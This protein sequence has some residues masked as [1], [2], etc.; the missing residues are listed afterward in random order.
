[1]EGAPAKPD[2]PE[3]SQAADTGHT[4]GR[5][6]D[7]R[8]LALLALGALVGLALA[9]WS[10]LS[11]GNDDDAP[12]PEGAVAV[13]NGAPIRLEDY[14]RLLDG[15][16][17]D[18]REP[19]DEARRRHVLD[20]MI[21]EELLVQKAIAL[22]LA[23]LDRR[24]R[25]ELTSSVIQ[26]VVAA[27]EDREPEE[28]E[29]RRFYDENRAFFSLPP[30]L[31]VR[32]VF[33]KLPSRAS[34]SDPDAEARIRARAQEAHDLLAAGQPFEVV[35]AGFG[36]EEVSPVP[37]AL[38]PPAKLREYVGP[39]ALA[40]ALELEQ[41]GISDP[42]RSGVGLH[43]IQLVEREPERIPPFEAVI[44]QVAAEWRRRAGDEALR[45]YLEE[46]RED[47]DVRVSSALP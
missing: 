30:R 28:D 44:P 20:R 10:L 7:R 14:R 47:A 45:A 38:L 11:G 36:D 12:V 9:T 21:E 41:G 15:L 24:V 3:A 35:R 22:G 13:V 46:L 37:D 4:G 6:G 5:S 23:R 18:L 2:S 33:L 34:A 43:V 27:A 31:R 19:I 29:L 1:M 40:A 32:Q 25:G 42:V 17:R 16:E 8:A 26:S 39:S